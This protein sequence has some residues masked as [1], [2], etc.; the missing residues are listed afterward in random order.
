MNLKRAK[1][2]RKFARNMT[3]GQIDRQLLKGTGSL[4]S[5]LVNHTESTRGVYRALKRKWRE[6]YQS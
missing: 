1:R 3:V 2:L 5:S 6:N 4:R